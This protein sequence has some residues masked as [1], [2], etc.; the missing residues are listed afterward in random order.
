MLKLIFIVFFL[1]FTS[2]VSA[3]K[4]PEWVRNIRSECSSDDICAVGSGES[5]DLAMSNARSNIQKIFETKVNSTFRS[6][7]SS[8]NASVNSFTTDVIQEDSSGLLKGVAITKTAEKNNTFYA[9]AVLNKDVATNELKA[10]IERIDKEMKDLL[11][12]SKHRPSLKKLEENY[13]ARAILNNKYIFLGKKEISEVVSY[14]DIMAIKRDLRKNDKSIYYINIDNEEITNVVTTL[15]IENN[16]K[17]TNNPEKSTKTIRGIITIKKDSLNVPGFEK[18]S[19]TFQLIVTSDGIVSN[20]INTTISES[21][22]NFEQIYSK[23]LD[24]FLT[25]TINNFNNLVD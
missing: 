4:L 19:G 17:I 3:E 20:T 10:D 25:F 18:H 21:G 11:L 8:R 15:L 14:E 22:T 23:I 7:L 2:A 9:L 24:K 12:D 5:L 6:E 1:V 13:K 16:L